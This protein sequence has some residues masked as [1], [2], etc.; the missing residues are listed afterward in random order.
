MRGQRPEQEKKT[1]VSRGKERSGKTNT[2][3]ESN[4]LRKEK[5][6]LDSSSNEMHSKRLEGKTPEKEIFFENAHEGELRQ[7][8]K[9]DKWKQ[10]KREGK[11]QKEGEGS[12]TPKER[13][14]EPRQ[15]K[16]KLA[17]HISTQK[18]ENEIDCS[19]GKVGN[20]EMR[21]TPRQ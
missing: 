18:G 21:L 1:R 8:K 4:K 12:Q 3:L 2:N 17:K 9:I 14:T 7:F 6:I 16:K 19:T 5:E 10:D 15:R 13:G 20:L 11:N